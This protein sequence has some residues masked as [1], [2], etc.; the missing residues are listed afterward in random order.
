[1]VDSTPFPAPRDDR[2]TV[3]IIADDL[4]GAADSAVACVTRGLEAR[5]LLDAGRTEIDA[6]VL[7]LDA[8]TRGM[9]ALAAAGEMRRL[10][11]IHR[12]RGHRLMFK[13][14]DSLLRGHV[15]EELA[16][17]LGGRESSRAVTSERGV[18]VLAPA[19]PRLGRTTR[20]GHQCLDGITLER[21]ETWRLE[22]MTGSSSLADIVAAAGLVAGLISL[23]AVRGGDGWLRN[24][25]TDL[26]DRVD[27]LVCDAES[28]ADLAAVARASFSLGRRAICAGSAGLAGHLIDAAGLTRPARK[29]A[30]EM[31]PSGPLLYVVGSL[32]PVSRRQ[33]EAL[34]ASGGVAAIEID[35]GALHRISDSTAAAVR[36]AEAFEAGEDVLVLPAPQDFPLRFDAA[37]VRAALADL[38]RPHADRIGGLFA[39]GGETARCVLAALGIVA[40]RPIMEVEPGVPLSIADGYR[41]M[42]IVTKAGAFG[43]PGTMLK[44]RRALREP[45]L[46]R[47]VAARRIG[48]VGS[49]P[50]H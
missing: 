48:E 43:G 16:A 25:M 34:V 42:P 5:V 6:E 36:V 31:P 24:V 40:F 44:C 3:V 15:G 28:E 20:G 4:S 10:F 2:P 14:L 33:A 39:T 32:S 22:G 49:W 45:N 19:F 46:A 13:K 37:S 8:D 50:V 30:E 47:A 17:I 29:T 7:A 12:G 23:D 38:A 11:E 18:A 9:A 41:A 35:V 26:A 27:V 21:T 1:M